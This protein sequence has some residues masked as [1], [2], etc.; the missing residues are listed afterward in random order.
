MDEAE[1]ESPRVTDDEAGIRGLLGM[2]DVPAFARRGMDLE[3]SLKR[4]HERLDQQRSALL[5]MVRLRLKQWALVTTGPG[6]WR[7]IFHGPIEPLY[8]L[9][10][11]NPPR[12]AQRPASARN[13]LAVGRDLV[14]SVSRFN[15]RWLQS[16][17]LLKLDTINHQI[18]HY[19]R[20]YVLEKECVMGS[21]RLASRHF[22][23]QPCL[24]RA[25]LLADH[26]ALPVPIL[27]A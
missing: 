25:R 2:F 10:E 4:L 9:S 24:S 11:A 22:V 13:R 12:W 5:D 20:Y 21:A 7:D 3:Y 14:T 6:D 8:T 27:I 26:P 17:D 23:P 19:N 15:R 16:L 18:E 1:N